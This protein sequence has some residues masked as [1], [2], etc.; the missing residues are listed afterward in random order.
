MLQAVVAIV[1]EAMTYLDSAPD[2]DTRVELIKTLNNVSAGK[3]LTS[4]LLAIHHGGC[5][6]LGRRKVMIFMEA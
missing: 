1:Q 2:E 3:V 5:S 4:T 6:K